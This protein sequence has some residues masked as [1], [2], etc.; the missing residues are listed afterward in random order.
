MFEI[1]YTN[2]VTKQ[3]DKGANAYEIDVKMQLTILKPINARW[4]ISLYDYLRTQQEMIRKGFDMAG[5][6]VKLLK[7]N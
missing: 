6:R 5:V 7:L 3:L 2:E 4:L 1:W